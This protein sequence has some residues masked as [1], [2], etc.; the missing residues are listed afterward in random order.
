[1]SETTIEI[2]TEA[3]PDGSHR[4]DG[5]L[6]AD[7]KDAIRSW[8]LTPPPLGEPGHAHQIAPP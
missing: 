1:M 3:P 4:S 8:A 6:D 7:E 5:H 2:T